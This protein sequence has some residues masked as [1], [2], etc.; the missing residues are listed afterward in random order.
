MARIQGTVVPEAAITE[1]GTIENVSVVAGHP[2]MIDN[3]VDAVR[4]WRYEPA[5]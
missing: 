3:A 4:Q 2:M 5:N 1:S